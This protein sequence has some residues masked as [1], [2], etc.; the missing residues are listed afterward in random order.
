ME[1]TRAALTLLLAF[2]VLAATLAC[3]GDGDGDQNTDRLSG[4][5][6]VFAAAS[7]SDAFTEMGEAFKQDQPGASLTFNFAGSQELRAQLEQGARADIFASA[8]Q[9]Q[10]NLAIKADLIDGQPEVFVKNRLAVIIPKA[11]EAGI[12]TLEDLAETGL[13]LVIASP[14]VPV[15]GYSRQLLLR[16]SDHP[17]FGPDYDV[18]VLANVV[19]EEG[20]VKQVVAK[21]QLDEAD[22]GIVY[23]S[24]VTPSVADAVSVIG[25]PDE[26]NQ[27]ASY[28]IAVTSEA[29][30]PDLAERFI[31]FVLSEEGQAILAGHGFLEAAR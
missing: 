29:S 21:V 2:P 24:D 13:K 1:W 5:I 11:N 28:P 15:G 10:M 12:G 20:N 19:S 30:S 22:G 14:D 18:R 6:T 8:D 17:D 27:V 26:L 9:A 23:E 3:G 25:I 16:A 4:E 31:A 7:L